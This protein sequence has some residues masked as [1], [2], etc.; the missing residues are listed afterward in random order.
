MCILCELQVSDRS[1][2]VAENELAFAVRDGFPVIPLHTL[3][4]PKRHAEDY[5]ALDE[6]ELAAINSLLHVQKRELEQHDAA[7][8]GF[9]IGMNCGE[10]AGQTVFHC[11]VHLI[12]RRFG[13]VE[14]PR[15][16]VRH[17]IPGKGTY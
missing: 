11:H 16:G 13:D 9:N 8:Q 1:R 7:I 12:P 14:S 4:I 3:I 15:G 2:I 5:F 10:V 6:K 17:V